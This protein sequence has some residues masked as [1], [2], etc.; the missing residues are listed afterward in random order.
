MCQS[1]FPLYP[2][3]QF[4]WCHSSIMF[5]A[6]TNLHTSTVTDLSSSFAVIYGLLRMLYMQSSFSLQSENPIRFSLQLWSQAAWGRRQNSTT[7]FALVICTF[8]AMLFWN[9]S[10][11]VHYVLPH[12]IVIENQITAASGSWFLSSNIAGANLDLVGYKVQVPQKAKSF[13]RITVLL[14][15]V[16]CYKLDNKIPSP[17]LQASGAHIHLCFPT[18]VSGCDWSPTA[19]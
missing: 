16:K 4:P 13:R 12:I 15:V 2:L 8:P 14:N 5:L 3:L 17:Q 19:I 6:P 7:A 10:D 9:T 18:P 11:K 1:P